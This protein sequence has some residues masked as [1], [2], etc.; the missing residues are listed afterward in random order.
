MPLPT[1]PWRAY[2]ASPQ[3]RTDNNN[4]FP[5]V[6]AP[7]SS[8]QPQQL[9][10]ARKPRKK[11]KKKTSLRVLPPGLR[12]RLP[13]STNQSHHF[14]VVCN[15]RMIVTFLFVFLLLTPPRRHTWPFSSPK[16]SQVSKLSQVKSSLQ[17]KSSQV[18]SS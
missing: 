5:T 18:K 4:A 10:C 9:S 8:I 13:R 11:K 1:I 14:Q 12:G 2:L 16:S 7:F 15:L 17:V 3:K 6:L